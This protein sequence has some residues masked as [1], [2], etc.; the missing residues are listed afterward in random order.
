MDLTLQALQDAVDLTAKQQRSLERAVKLL[1]TAGAL[2]KP[3]KPIEP[4]RQKRMARARDVVLQLMH[5]HWLLHQQ[6]CSSPNFSHQ[7]ITYQGLR[8]GQLPVWLRKNTDVLR[9]GEAIP[10]RV[11]ADAANQLV[12]AGHLHR[13]PIKWCPLALSPELMRHPEQIPACAHDGTDSTSGPSLSTEPDPY[14]MHQ[15]RGTGTLRYD[16]ASKLFVFELPGIEKPGVIIDPQGNGDAMERALKPLIGQV[17][18]FTGQL[19]GMA[20]ESINSLTIQYIEIFPAEKGAVPS[21]LFGVFSGNLGKKPELNDS[22]ASAYGSMAVQVVPGADPCWLRLQASAARPT[23]A[24]LL[25]LD[26]GTGVI[27]MGTLSSYTY[28]RK[29]TQQAATGVSLEVEAI[30]LLP[31]STRTP[32]FSQPAPMTTAEVQND[33]FLDAA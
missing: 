30:S 20:G 13:L 17:M 7:R 31:R 5:R 26:K 3:P 11:L 16:E 32:I 19:F 25:S 14:P 22:G 12:A 27:V 2:P 4:P 29:D 33:A 15:A 10:K 24:N 8:T 9:P 23:H 1:A 6:G 28:T 18:P 21:P